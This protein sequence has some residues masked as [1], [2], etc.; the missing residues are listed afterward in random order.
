MIYALRALPRGDLSQRNAEIKV[1]MM[2]KTILWIAAV[3]LAMP[4]IG[5]FTGGAV[6]VGDYFFGFVFAIG[7]VI[8]GYFASKK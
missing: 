3:L 5:L 4:A 2:G 7:A 8:F 6:T 1:R